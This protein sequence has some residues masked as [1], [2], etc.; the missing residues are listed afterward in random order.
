MPDT[1]EGKVTLAVL[2]TKLDFIAELLTTHIEKDEECHER[3][4]N[5][6]Q[7][8]ELNMARI[9]T[10][11]SILAYFQSGFSIIVGA[12]AAFLGVR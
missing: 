4:A 7:M 11:Q 2:A 10:K 6:L 1:V 12:I 8:L 5:R 9:E 3:H